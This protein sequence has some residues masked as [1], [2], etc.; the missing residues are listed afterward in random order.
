M[1]TTHNRI[2]HR[3]KRQNSCY[4]E[5]VLLQLVQQLSRITVPKTNQKRLVRSFDNRRSQILVV[6]CPG[7]PGYRGYFATFQ[8]RCLKAFA[9][10]IMP[11]TTHQKIAVSC[12]TSEQPTLVTKLDHFKTTSVEIILMDTFNGFP[13][14]PYLNQVEEFVVLISDLN[15]SVQICSR[16]QSTTYLPMKS[17]RV[18]DH[19]FHH[20]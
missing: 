14:S 3:S 16:Q 7:N 4:F 12:A 15:N 11:S 6:R 10:P 20:V 5:V 1:R 9:C 13:E 17:H 18:T 8:G 2:L 19:I